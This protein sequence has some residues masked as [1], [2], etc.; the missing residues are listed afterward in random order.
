MVVE[1]IRYSIDSDR[2]QAF[3]RRPD[4]RC[5]SHRVGLGR[6]TPVG[7]SPEPPV[8]QLLR[9]GRPVRTRR[10]QYQCANRQAA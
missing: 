6:G 7:V 5:R 3:E 10:L 9:G 4:P 1:Y 2:V 8:P